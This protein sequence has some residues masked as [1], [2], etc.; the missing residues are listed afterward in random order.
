M[1]GPRILVVDDDRLML[2]MLLG[3]LKHEGYTALERASSGK[4][5]VARFLQQRSEIVLL[6][7]E[8]PDMS[9]LD[10]LRAIKEFGIVTQVVMVSASPT[11]ANVLGAKEGGAACFLVKPVSPKKIA[12]T[13]NACLERAQQEEG[14]I[15]LFI[16][17]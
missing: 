1:A 17:A 10:V 12:N 8:M 5:A 2:T 3:V 11:Q 4:D 9:G 13:I 6:D 16:C 15:E 7:I 14:G